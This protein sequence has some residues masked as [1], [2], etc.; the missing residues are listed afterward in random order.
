MKPCK[1]R[2]SQLLAPLRVHHLAS[3]HAGAQLRLSTNKA[4]QVKLTGLGR[5][6]RV[7]RDL[8]DLASVVTSEIA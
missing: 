3:T 8:R 4:R 1:I 7:Y 5:F 2:G 6:V